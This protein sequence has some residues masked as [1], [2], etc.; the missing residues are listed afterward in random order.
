[1]RLNILKIPSESASIQQ[2]VKEILT[3]CGIMELLE[4]TQGVVML[5]RASFQTNFNDIDQLS[6]T[7]SKCTNNFANII[8]SIKTEEM[9]E[10]EIEITLLIA[11]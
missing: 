9:D 11:E 4:K 8:W 6:Q 7:I 2:N 10:D 1:M 5:F 3:N